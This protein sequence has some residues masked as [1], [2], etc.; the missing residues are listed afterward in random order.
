MQ[1]K[2]NGELIAKLANKRQWFNQVPDILPKLPAQEK[3]LFVDKNG[4]ILTIGEDFMAAEKQ[5]SY[6][7][8]IYHLTRTSKNK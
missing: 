3:L 8:S 1:I 7:V 5:E 4:N 6:P 2:I